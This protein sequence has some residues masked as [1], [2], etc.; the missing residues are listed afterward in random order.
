MHLCG[1]FCAPG[2]GSVLSRERRRSS[3]FIDQIES[4]E[5]CRFA[6]CPT[7]RP[8]P[9]SLDCRCA[10]GRQHHRQR[11]PRP[12]SSCRRSQHAAAKVTRLKVPPPLLLPLPVSLL[13]TPS[14]PRS[15]S[16]R[17][18]LGSFHERGQTRTRRV[19]KRGCKEKGST[20]CRIQMLLCCLRGAGGTCRDAQCRLGVA[21]R[22]FVHVH[23]HRRLAD[24]D[25]RSRRTWVRT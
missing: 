14:L 16:S 13:Y 22:W 10:C 5:A 18:C 12:C 4:T 11:P 19:R 20:R 8:E 17:T 9:S 1:A 2:D 23:A 15:A 24:Q 6:L 25:L 21:R 7:P 3:E